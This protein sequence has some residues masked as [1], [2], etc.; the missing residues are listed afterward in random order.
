MEAPN[1][2]GAL[3]LGA[4]VGTYVQ[5][6]AS[7]LRVDLEILIGEVGRAQRIRQPRLRHRFQED[8]IGL[9]RS[10]HWLRLTDGGPRLDSVDRGGTPEQHILGAVYAAGARPSAIRAVSCALAF[11]GGGGEEMLDFI[12]RSLRGGLGSPGGDGCEMKSAANLWALEVLGFHPQLGIA[13]RHVDVQRSFRRLVA[14]AHPDS[15]GEG[16]EAAARISD[17]MEARR[18]LLR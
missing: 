7:E 11:T 10:T 3:L 15:G 16:S 8:L 14:S 6:C 1:Q 18:I 5:R 17:L 12:R 9:T 13:P 4:V 2:A